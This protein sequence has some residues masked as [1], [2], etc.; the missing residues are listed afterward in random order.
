MSDE[1]QGY[2]AWR[3]EQQRRAQAHAFHWAERA[4]A[5]YGQAIEYE[6]RGRELARQPFQTDAA[7]K[8]QRNA[9]QHGARSTEAI[10][11]AEMWSHVADA[12]AD[13]ELPVANVLE[14]HDAEPA[15]DGVGLSDSMAALTRR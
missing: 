12:L 14:V 13:G 5:E 15:D 7:E 11:L 2:G 6:D 8:E 10:K 4:T 3:T 9:R 1:E